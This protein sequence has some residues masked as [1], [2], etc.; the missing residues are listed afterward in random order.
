MVDQMYM[1]LKYIQLS[2]HPDV[3]FYVNM[4]C[5]DIKRVGVV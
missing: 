3:L 1:L 2:I 4:L 5:F